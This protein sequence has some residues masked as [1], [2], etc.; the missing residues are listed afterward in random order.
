VSGK[1][2]Q[3][4]TGTTIS[5]KL[6]KCPHAVQPALQQIYKHHIYLKCKQAIPWHC[7][8]AGQIC[9][10][11]MFKILCINARQSMCFPLLQ[12][13]PEPQ[14]HRYFDTK[15]ALDGI[16]DTCSASV[17]DCDV[18]EIL[19]TSCSTTKLHQ[20]PVGR[21]MQCIQ[22]LAENLVSTP[23]AHGNHTMYHQE[24]MCQSTYMPYQLSFHAC[25]HLLCA[26]RVCEHP[27][28]AGD[29]VVSQ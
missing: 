5:C 17:N 23:A 1:L 10:R 18:P 9:S 20:Q 22:P 8:I 6:V 11:S 3:F 29:G 21:L 15:S 25:L 12:E 26:L 27:W 28:L 24:E 7:T 19:R 14:K 16:C 4:S 13:D 2:R